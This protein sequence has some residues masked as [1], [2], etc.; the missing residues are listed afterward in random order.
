[1]EQLWNMREKSQDDFQILGL[2]NMIELPFT[3]T[4]EAV[5]TVG[6]KSQVHFG[7]YAWVTQSVKCLTINLSSGHVLTF[8]L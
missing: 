4:R 6:W 3:E 7:G 8:G 1:M 5:K 2:S